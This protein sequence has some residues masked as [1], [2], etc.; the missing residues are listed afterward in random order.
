MKKR[1]DS[2]L[3]EKGLFPSREQAARAIR[4]G[5]IISG[6]RKVDK[7]GQTLDPAAEIEVLE[8]PRYVSRG[9]DKLAGALAELGLGV[10]GMTALDAGCST[11]GFTDCLLQNGVSRVYAF[12]VGRGQ[13]AW[14]LRRD[15]RVVLKEGCNVRYLQPSDLPEK[16]DLAVADLSFISLEKVLP[17]LF[18]LLRDG[19]LLLALVKPQFEAA[20]GEVGRGGVVRDDSVRAAAVKR[21]E[22]AVAA[23]GHLVLKTV[24]SVLPGPAGNVEFFLLAQKLPANRE[25]P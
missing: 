18:P 20:R 10:A 4:A 1:A 14:K 22:T 11:G 15:S 9:G 7:P 25:L 23:L 2:L 24:V 16:V 19:G 13:I 5:W 3:V 17:A 8:R 12:D 21:V 6:G